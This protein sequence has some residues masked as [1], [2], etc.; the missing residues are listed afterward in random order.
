MPV[1]QEI[2]EWWIDTYEQNVLHGLQQKESRLEGTVGSFVITGERRRF[3]YIGKRE[4]KEL[5]GSFEDTEYEDSRYGT[6]WAFT[7]PYYDAFKTDATDIEKAFTDPTSDMTVEAVNAARRL[8]DKVIIKSLTAKVFCGHDADIIEEFPLEDNTID[9]QT[10]SGASPSNQGLNLAKLLEAKYRFD[11]A[12]ID[13]QDPRYFII[14]AKQLQD[15]LNVTEIKNKDYNTVQALVEGRI[16]EYLGF[17]FIR[18]E[19][20][21]LDTETGIRTCHAYTRNSMKFG[22]RKGITVKSA[23]VPTKH[24]NRVTEIFIDLGAVRLY[25]EGVLAIPCAE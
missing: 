23:E 2:P 17:H 6:R 3:N 1:T 7:K 20:L 15:L 19:L 22:M 11:K 8:K 4:M 5:V 9:I 14:T 21:P 18:T 25:D 16:N 24:F 10:G 12:D 13:E